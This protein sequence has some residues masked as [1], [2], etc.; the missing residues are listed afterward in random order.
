MLSKSAGRGE[1]S[2]PNF[3]EQSTNA[4]AAEKYQ[5]EAEDLSEYTDTEL[6]QMYYNGEITRREYEAETGETLEVDQ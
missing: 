5:Y 3:L 1:Q 2:A 6:K 4:A